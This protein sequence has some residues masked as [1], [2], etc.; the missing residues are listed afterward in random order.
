LRLRWQSGARATE[1]SGSHP[2]VR[3]AVAACRAAFGQCPALLH[4][5][6]TIPIVDVLQRQMGIPVLMLGFAHPD[7]GA[8][9]PNERFSLSTFK[10]AIATSVH[11]LTLMGGTEIPEGCP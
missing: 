2:L 11:L 8:H 6:G 1:I 4:C 7:D 10:R 9:A 3:V 5:G